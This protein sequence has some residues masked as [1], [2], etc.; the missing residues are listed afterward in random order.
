M[1]SGGF[2]PPPPGPKPGILTEL[3]YDP[4][5]FKGFISLINFAT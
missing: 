1:G 4:L 2:E 3:Y 5:D